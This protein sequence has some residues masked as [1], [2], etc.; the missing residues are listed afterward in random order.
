MQSPPQQMES[1]LTS[2]ASDLAA[3]GHLTDIHMIIVVNRLKT[4]TDR[5]SFFLHHEHSV[6]IPP[7]Y[8]DTIGQSVVMKIIMHGRMTIITSQLDGPRREWLDDHDNGFIMGLWLDK[9]VWYF[10]GGE[11]T[12]LR[13]KNICY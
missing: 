5:L 2:L 12:N 1:Y 7:K 11:S 8:M 9:G 13:A 6:T 3:H 10:I 4:Q